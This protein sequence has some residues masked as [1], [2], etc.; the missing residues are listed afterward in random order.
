MKCLEKDRTRRYETANALA[1]DVER[2]L[3]DEPVEACPPSSGYRMRKFASKHRKAIATAL[4]FLLMLGLMKAIAIALAVMAWKAEARA[5]EQAMVAMRAEAM[6]RAER[7][8]AFAAESL[9]IVAGTEAEAKR[10]EAEAARQSLRRSLYTSDILLA[11][12]AWESG[13]LEQLQGLLDREGRS[14]AR[15][16]CGASSGTTSSGGIPPSGPSSLEIRRDG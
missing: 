2:F 5:R 11:S 12:K 8:K 6:A 10:E 15:S 4:A 14:P 13:N 16:N 9:A 3:L 7:D 1:R